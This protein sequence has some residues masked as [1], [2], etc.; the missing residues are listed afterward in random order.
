MNVNKIKEILTTRRISIK[1]FAKDIG[2]TES[3]FHKALLNNTFKV[4]TLEKIS[5]ELHIPTTFWFDDGKSME[6]NLDNAE[7]LEK[8][9]MYLMDK[10]NDL[11]RIIKLKDEKVDYLEGML[12]YLE[13]KI[14]RLE[15][16]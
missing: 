2:M 1:D 13:R 12:S 15:M 7:Y 16:K 6:M 3:G 14:T 11:N 4:S 9:N 10:I 5:A 8:D